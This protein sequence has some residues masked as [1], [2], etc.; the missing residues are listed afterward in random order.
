VQ[1]THQDPRALLAELASIEAEI[2][3]EVEA[4]RVSLVEVAE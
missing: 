1:A 2:A 4:L 3:E